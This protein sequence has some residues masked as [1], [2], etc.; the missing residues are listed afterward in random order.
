MPA[1]GSL[2]LVSDEGDGGWTVTSDL[3][4]PNSGSGLFG[5]TSTRFSSRVRLGDPGRTK[6][7]KQREEEKRAEQDRLEKLEL[8]E[9]SELIQ[10]VLCIQIPDVHS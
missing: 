4:S 10:A 5:G 8:E 2:P 9:E 3:A 1:A 7:E 6:S